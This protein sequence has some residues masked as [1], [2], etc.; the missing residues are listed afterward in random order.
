MAL[1][2]AADALRGP[3][4]QCLLWMTFGLWKPGSWHMQVTR[5]A[6]VSEGTRGFSQ[7]T[8]NTPYYMASDDTPIVAAI[9]FRAADGASVSAGSTNFYNASV[10]QGAFTFNLSVITGFRGRKSLYFD[11]ISLTFTN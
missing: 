1:A 7:V 11:T 4:K 10:E 5:T 9:S 6:S 8:G 2:R 3:N